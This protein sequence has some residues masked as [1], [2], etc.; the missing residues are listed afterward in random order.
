MN[1]LWATLNNA[2]VAPTRD[3]LGFR[4]IIVLTW[5]HVDAMFSEVAARSQDDVALGAST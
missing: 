1:P 3:V 4:Q 2:D 5:R